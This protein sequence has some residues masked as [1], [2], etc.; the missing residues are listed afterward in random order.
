MAKNINTSQYFNWNIAVK[1]MYCI[2]CTWW[3]SKLFNRSSSS[4]IKLISSISHPP[5]SSEF[6]TSLTT[7]QRKSKQRKQK[8]RKKNMSW[9]VLFLQRTIPC[10]PSS[11]DRERSRASRRVRERDRALRDERQFHLDDYLTNE[12][13]T[14]SLLITCRLGERCRKTKSRAREV[15]VQIFLGGP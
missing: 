10:P 6:T 4:S 5:V 1:E 7:R 13:Q 9:L 14:P 2:C 3:S 8:E 12:P 15:F 11:G